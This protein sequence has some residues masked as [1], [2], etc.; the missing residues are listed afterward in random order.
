MTTVTLAEY[1][2]TSRR[3]L[4]EFVLGFFNGA[5]HY[6]GVEPVTASGSFP[7]IDVSFTH[8]QLPENL[9]K[10]LL[11]IVPD[12]TPPKGLEWAAKSGIRRQVDTL[13]RLTLFTNQS[14]GQ[15]AHDQIVDLLSLILCG[16]RATLAVS[17]LKIVRVGGSSGL[18]IAGRCISQRTITT[19]FVGTHGSN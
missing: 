10:P 12:P 17:K 14:D 19:R 18:N 15:L 16:A 3:A 8:E 6:V 13:W 11:S 9:S 1:E 2:V 7:D 4:G 5:E